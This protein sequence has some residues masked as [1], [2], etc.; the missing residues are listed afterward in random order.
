MKLN[1]LDTYYISYDFT[2]SYI[3]WLIPNL[4]SIQSQQSFLITVLMKFQTVR[5][6]RN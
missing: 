6:T 5:D 3:F 4:I 1:T 2:V